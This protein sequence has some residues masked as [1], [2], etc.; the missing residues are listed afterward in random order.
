MRVPGGSLAAFE[1]EL[2]G[3]AVH[4]HREALKEI[5]AQKT[6]DEQRGVWM[7]FVNPNFQAFN[8]SI[9]DLKRLELD[10]RHVNFGSAYDVHRS[11]WCV[12]PRG[13]SQALG[14]SRSD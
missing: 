5:A 14:E 13:D 11:F 4:G 7:H 3:R 10:E 6:I 1:P 9:P 2:T 8:K 12:G